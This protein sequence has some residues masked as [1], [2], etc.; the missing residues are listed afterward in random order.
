[1]AVCRGRLAAV[2]AVSVRFR[3]ADGRPSGAIQNRA[4]PRLIPPWRPRTSPL[5]ATPISRRSE[6]R[7]PVRI[8]P[9]FCLSLRFRPRELRHLAP[10]LGLD[11]EWLIGP[12]ATG[13]ILAQAV[14][15][16]DVLVQNVEIPTGQIWGCL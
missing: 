6:P 1:M 12:F 3:G 10:P 13:W 15:E 5:R 9:P 11:D 7:Q 14:F 8:A 16:A 2:R 4:Q